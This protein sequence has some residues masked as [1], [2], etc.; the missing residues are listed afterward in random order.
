VRLNGAK[1]NNVV[2]MKM[3][4]KKNDEYDFKKFVIQDY[5]SCLKLSDR[6]IIDNILRLINKSYKKNDN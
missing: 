5:V 6:R 4:E 3:D 2:Y 1:K